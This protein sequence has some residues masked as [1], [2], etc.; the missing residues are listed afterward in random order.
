MWGY[1]ALN[2]LGLMVEMG[3]GTKASVIIHIWSSNTSCAIYV[4][5]HSQAALAVWENDIEPW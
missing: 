1:N 5:F 2:M 4:L 3:L